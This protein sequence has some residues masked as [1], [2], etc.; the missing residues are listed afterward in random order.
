METIGLK[1]TSRRCSD[2]KCGARLK[3]TVLDWEVLEFHLLGCSLITGG[4]ANALSVARMLCHQ[5]K[6]I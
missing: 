6:C 1:E 2:G 5:R 4:I 3:D